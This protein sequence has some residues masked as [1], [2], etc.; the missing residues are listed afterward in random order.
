[1]PKPEI[2]VNIKINY[3]N[4]NN[5]YEKMKVYSLRT[6][7]SDIIQEHLSDYLIEN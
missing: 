1:M 7:A 5:E 4:K 3:P 2:A 6:F